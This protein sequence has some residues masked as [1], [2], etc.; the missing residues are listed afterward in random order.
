MSRLLEILETC[1][2]L[3]PGER[4]L[5]GCSGGQDS[6]ALAHALGRIRP[7]LVEAAV[8]DHGMRPNSDQEAR[9]VSRLVNGWHIPCVVLSPPLEPEGSPEDRLRRQRRQALA[10]LAHT[11]GIGILVLAHHARDQLE[12][13]LMRLMRGTGLEGL[14]GMKPV[15]SW[16]PHLRVVRPVLDCDPNILAS[17][18]SEHGLRPWEDPTNLDCTI[19]RNR[20]RHEVLPPLTQLYPGWHQTLETAI[21]RWREEDAY[22]ERQVDEAWT[23]L[24]PRELEGFVAWPTLDFLALDPVIQR[25]LLRRATRL[26]GRL[27]QDLDARRIEH[28]RTG[29]EPL[30]DIGEGI[31]IE[32]RHGWMVL[33]GA[34][35]QVEAGQ[36]RDAEHELRLARPD[37]DLF[38]PAGRAHIRTLRHHL[39]KRRIPWLVQERLLVLARENLV[40]A[41]MGG[42]SADEIGLD[43]LTIRHPQGRWPGEAWFDKGGPPP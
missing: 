19:P 32:R 7:G 30:A 2:W 29:H 1:P 12:T 31:R 40:L 33:A 42:P 24:A 4:M 20:I 39:G 14:T 16:G 10:T 38:R 13:V 3:P 21:H 18:A 26:A 6:L 35:P 27:V 34:P 9:E 37:R 15:L 28:V 8:V 43:P 17:H 23:G 5:V 11:R 22:L 36:M 25:R 41:V